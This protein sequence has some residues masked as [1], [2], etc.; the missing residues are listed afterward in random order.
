MI[1]LDIEQGYL[2]IGELL[3]T[4]DL[5]LQDIETL[6]QQHEVVDA[7]INPPHKS[8]RM[9]ALDDGYAGAILMFYNS[10]LKNVIFG[11]GRKFDFPPFEITTREIVLVKELL[12][13]L[14]GEKS[15]NWGKVEYDEDYRAGS[16]NLFLTY[17]SDPS[18]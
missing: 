15:Y 9:S 17:F 2:Q 11:L 5:E 4:P 12:A 3:I 1:S 8:Y 18:Q 10:K 16:V 6:K 14:G 7:V 13:E